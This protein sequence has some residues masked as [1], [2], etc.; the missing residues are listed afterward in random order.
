[1]WRVGMTTQITVET[2]DW[3]VEVIITDQLNETDTRE[4]T[5]TVSPHSQRVYH[6]TDTRSVSFTEMPKDGEDASEV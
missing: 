6:L 4:T 1:M 2:V 3:P 5:E